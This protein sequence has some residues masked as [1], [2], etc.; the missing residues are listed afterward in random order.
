M[1]RLAERLRPGIERLGDWYQSLKPRERVLV[2]AAACGLVVALWDVLLLRPMEAD[3][4]AQKAV[5]VSARE[6]LQTVEAE[7]AM[8]NAQL[9]ANPNQQLQQ[10]VNATFEQVRAVGDQLVDSSEAWVS[11]AH[12]V[13]V[14][15]AILQEQPGVK[16]LALENLPPRRLGA[17][18]EPGGQP[19][20]E[21][22][23]EHAVEVTLE[24]DYFSLLGY[25]EALE[26]SPWRFVWDRLEYEVTGYPLARVQ[27]RLKTLSASAEALEIGA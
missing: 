8:L 1:R 12:M 19:A 2:L 22:I 6:S 18:P 5:L 21:S 25:I 20:G 14:L 16:L 26:A 10:R 9:L 7:Q 13:E 17:D 24:A 23:Y 3:I 15:H 4:R 11:P 27:L